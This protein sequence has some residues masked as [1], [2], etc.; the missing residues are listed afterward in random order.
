M[1]FASRIAVV[2]SGRKPPM[3]YVLAVITSFSGSDPNEVILKARGR[4]IT[5]AVDGGENT[6]RRFM[7]E[8]KASEVTTGTETIQ[9]EEGGT[10]NILTPSKS[11]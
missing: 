9:Q 7:K 2:Y 3:N 10:R 8:L 6:R 1:Y 5:R 4:G 11:R